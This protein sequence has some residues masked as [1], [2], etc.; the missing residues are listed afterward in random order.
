MLAGL[1]G[2]LGVFFLSFIGNSQP[3]LAEDYA[4]VSITVGM[5]MALIV[6]VGVQ[7]YDIVPQ[8]NA[9]WRSRPI[10][11]DLWFWTKFLSGL[12]ILLAAIY[13]PLIAFSL[14]GDDPDLAHAT[15]P[16]M[17]AM[18]TL[19][20]ALFAAAVAMTSLV[21]QAVY[22]AILSI[23][24]M[25]FGVVIVWLA[26]RFGLYERDWLQTIIYEMTEH[27]VALAMV[28]NFVVCTLVGWLAVRY[29]WGYKSKY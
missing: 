23:A 19:L 15:H 8:L 29:D 26:G 11:A 18:S 25:Y 4:F 1:I 6:G 17:I 10:N 21:R 16:D 5:L 9:F 20:I 12:A 7:F 24:A 3:G 27:Q 2:I 28:I 22:A 14:L 13:G